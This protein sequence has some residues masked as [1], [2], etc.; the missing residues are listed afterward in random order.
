MAQAGYCSECGRNVYL[1]SQGACPEGHG[2][3]CISNTYEV[4]DAGESVPAESLPPAM[5]ETSE[6]PAE[7]SVPAE[8]SEPVADASA[9][10]AAPVYPATAL[11][12]TPQRN[13]TGLIVIVIAAVLILFACL[14][15]GL[16]IIP[17]MQKTGTSSSSTT[18]ARAQVTTSIGFLH[19]LFGEDALG[20][21]PYLTDAAQ[22][23]ITAKQWQTIASAIATV[24]VT[25]GTPTWSSDTTAIV[26]FSSEGTT[27]TIA[28]GANEATTAPVVNLVLVASG[29]SSKAFV[30][31]VKVGSDWRIV[32]VTGDTGEKTTYDAAFVKNLANET[33]ASVAATSN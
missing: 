30:T 24:E 1:N 33:S 14:A 2:A 22:N 17:A 21:K 32:S 4:P 9:S 29:T 3:D 13:R 5:S 26:T 23:S 16:L 6:S 8:S 18:P 12:V 28:L 25:F 19:V 15:T 10:E 27:G 11:P 20:I 31:L 7:P